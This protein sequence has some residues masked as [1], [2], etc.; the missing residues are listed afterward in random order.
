MNIENSFDVPA[1][2]QQVYDLLS[3]IEQVAPC[4]PGATITGREGDDYSGRFRM[5]VG[6]V[7]AAYEG[8]I[9]VVS[10]DQERGEVV[11]RGSGTDPRGAGSAEATI[12]ARITPLESGTRIIMATSLEVGGRLAQ[13]TGRTSMMQSVADRMINQFA[14]GLTDRLAQGPQATESPSASSPATA[15]R[16]A[17]AGTGAALP[18]ADAAAAGVSRGGGEAFD[19]GSLVADMLKSRV[20]P[21]VVVGV[22]VGVLV[23]LGIGRRGN[24]PR[25]VVNL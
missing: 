5:K 21:L 19:A 16:H 1:Q 7:A 4:M 22:L 8:A 25:I 12:T 18:Q 2:A 11:L 6:P 14:A 20:E 24:R 10:R 3:D 15:P 17:E 23:G 9:A 13:F